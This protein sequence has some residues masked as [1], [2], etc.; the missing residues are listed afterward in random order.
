MGRLA[1]AGPVDRGVGGEVF[2]PRHLILYFEQLSELPSHRRNSTYRTS[3]AQEVVSARIVQC[4]GRHP[5]GLA[6]ESDSV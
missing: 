3:P 1:F 5:G 4:S 2:S 6:V